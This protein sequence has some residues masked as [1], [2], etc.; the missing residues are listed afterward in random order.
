MDDDRRRRREGTVP[1]LPTAMA[2]R[3][4]RL[5]EPGAEGVWAGI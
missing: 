1:R 2:M 5:Y 3:A 4:G